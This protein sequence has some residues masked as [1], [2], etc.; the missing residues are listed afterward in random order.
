MT[1]KKEKW[2]GFWP[3]ALQLY[4]VA[5]GENT[6]SKFV[7]ETEKPFTKIG[8]SW[9]KKQIS[10]SEPLNFFYFWSIYKP[11]ETNDNTKQFDR[12]KTMVI[13]LTQILLPFT[14]TKWLRKEKAGSFFYTHT[15]T[16]REQYNIIWE[17][18]P[19]SIELDLMVLRE[20]EIKAFR[21]SRHK[22]YLENLNLNLY[23]INNEI[24]LD[25]WSDKVFCVIL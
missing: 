19:C 13:V 4:W 24:G 16:E 23:D 10:K 7:R 18:G 5:W 17:R 8:I 12:N 25:V 9:G 21:C 2:E 15:E 6:I 3:F 1:R 14:K 20:S 22:Y 11:L